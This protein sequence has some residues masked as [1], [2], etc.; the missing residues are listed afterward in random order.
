MTDSCF[1]SI[2]N[3]ERNI[4]KDKAITLKNSKHRFF[5]SFMLSPEISYSS[6][7]GTD[8][9]QLLRTDKITAQESM[10]LEK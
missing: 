10:S 4:K 7:R 2:M 1:S 6:D 3:P 8:P 9:S 5:Q